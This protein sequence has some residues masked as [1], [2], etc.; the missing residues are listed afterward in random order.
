MSQM[1]CE[2]SSKFLIFAR[3]RLLFRHFVTGAAI[4]ATVWSR[5][6]FLMSPF[7]LHLQ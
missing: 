2:V 5:R 6:P 3:L 1:K 4:L 7:Y